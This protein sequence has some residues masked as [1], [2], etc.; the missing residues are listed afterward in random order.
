MWGHKSPRESHKTVSQ[1][2]SQ[3]HRWG[4]HHNQR[5]ASVTDGG[6]KMGGHKMGDTRANAHQVSQFH[7]M[8]DTRTND[9][10][11]SPITQCHN[12]CEEA[13]LWL[14]SELERKGTIKSEEE[15]V[16]RL[17]Q[18]SIGNEPNI[19]KLTHSTNKQRKV[20]F[21]KQKLTWICTYLY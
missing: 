14:K 6:H 10:Q 17:Y 15:L 7:K 16:V 20:R 18:A 8:G 12:K 13:L 2:V 11:G 9:Q 5:W 19:N 21:V 1:Q 4:R 3:C